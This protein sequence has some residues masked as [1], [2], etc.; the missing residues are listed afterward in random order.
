MRVYNCDQINSI[1]HIYFDFKAFWNPRKPQSFRNALPETLISVEAS[2]TEPKN[3]HLWKLFW[4]RILPDMAPLWIAHSIC[5]R[6]ASRGGLLDTGTLLDLW[7]RWNQALG[8][9]DTDPENKVVTHQ[10]LLHLICVFF[11]SLAGD[12]NVGLGKRA[13]Y[14]E[15][16]FLEQR[17]TQAIGSPRQATIISTWWVA[18]HTTDNRNNFAID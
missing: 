6:L 1:Y 17:R 2:K 3:Y 7:P 9:G 15:A 11:N 4:M 14:W 13:A 16:R 12:P 18:Y 5:L 8:F 10:S